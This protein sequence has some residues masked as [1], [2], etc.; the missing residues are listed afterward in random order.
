MELDV[1]F[2]PKKFAAGFGNLNFLVR[3]DGKKFVLR[4]PPMGPIPPGANDMAREHRV[5][6]HLHPVLPLVPEARHYCDDASVLGA[7]FLL[8][9]YRPGLVI[10]AT[11]PPDVGKVWH[12]DI[13]VGQ[14]LGSNMINVLAKLHAVDAQACGL[15]TLGKPDGFLERTLRGWTKRAALSWGEDVPDDLSATLHWL[16]ANRPPEAKTPTLIH[17][18]FKLDNIILDPDTLAP[19]TLIDWDM[20]TIGDPLYDLAVLLSYWSEAADPEAMHDLRQMPTAHSGFQTREEA[21]QLY[22]RASGRDLSNFTF[23]RVLATLRLAVVFQQLFRRHQ[24]NDTDNPRF[25][26]F[27][28]LALGLLSFALQISRGRSF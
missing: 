27:D 12:S 18:D 9:E 25:A 4:R 3:V 1:T 20:G 8:M 24:S 16:A 28:D 22:A 17:N 11:M 15:G 2:L 13:P 23:Y 5:L 10:G 6:S 21:A 7:P 26:G 19:R 14:F